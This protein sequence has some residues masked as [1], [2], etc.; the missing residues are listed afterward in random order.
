MSI[1]VVATLMAAPGKGQAYLDIF[2]HVCELVAQEPGCEQFEVFQSGI[3]PDKLV[4]LE[5]W[6][7]QAAFDAHLEMNKT[8]PPFPEDVAG[9]FVSREDY[10]YAVVG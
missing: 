8:R 1:R 5:R 10:A 6:S 3:D 2:K 9:P 7:D 4:L